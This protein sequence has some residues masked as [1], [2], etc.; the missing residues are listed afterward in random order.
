[1]HV[2][3]CNQ[4]RFTSVC[5]FRKNILQLKREIEAKRRR[6]QQLKEDIQRI[7]LQIAITEAMAKA[8]GGKESKKYVVL[9]GK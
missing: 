6:E 3:K 7:E 4:E 9:L 1:M 2:L 5:L 8:S